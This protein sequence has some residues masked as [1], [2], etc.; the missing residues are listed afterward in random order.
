MRD[1]EEEEEE[2]EEKKTRKPEGEEKVSLLSSME[3][4]AR[5]W[6]KVARRPKYA[7]INSKEDKKKRKKRERKLRYYTN[8][9]M[10]LR[11]VPAADPGVADRV[12]D[13]RPRR[14]I[15]DARYNHRVQPRPLSIA[16]RCSFRWLSAADYLSVLRAI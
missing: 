14:A 6:R 7:L 1:I 5:R 8:E 15:G 16:Q 10:N 12:F 4:T 11:V 3:S 13:A 9:L 2:E